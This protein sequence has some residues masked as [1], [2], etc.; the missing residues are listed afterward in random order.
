MVLNLYL[1]YVLS[2]IETRSC[3]KHNYLFTQRVSELLCLVKSSFTCVDEPDS[4]NLEDTSK[5]AKADSERSKN[6][7]SHSESSRNLL[8]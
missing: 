3:C 4:H 6:N 7:R 5:I 2:I 1:K 8:T